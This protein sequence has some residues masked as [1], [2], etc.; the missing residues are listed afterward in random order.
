MLFSV[1]IGNQQKVANDW[2]VRKDEF[3]QS[4]IHNDSIR[5]R[6]RLGKNV[7]K[8]LTVDY[9]CANVAAF[10][11]EDEP[12]E[13]LDA[14]YADV[15]AYKIANKTFISNNNKNMNL[16]LINFYSKDKAVMEAHKEDHIMFVTMVNDNYELVDYFAYEGVDIIQTY[17][18]KGLYQGCVVSFKEAPEEGDLLRLYVKDKVK[19]RFVSIDISMTDKNRI[20]VHKEGIVKDYLK[21]IRRIYK[22]LES[23]KKQEQFKI[24]VPEGKLL[25]RVYITTYSHEAELADILKDKGIKNFVI[26]SIDQDKLTKDYLKVDEIRNTLNAEIRDERIRAVTT[27]NIDMPWSFCKDF[28]IMY[29]FSYDGKK[30]LLTCLK[31]N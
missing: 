28:N 20:L 12:E 23:K 16:A 10:K 31:S 14:T 29:L 5:Q 8:H 1:I 21:T 11:F 7:P 18:K 19:N 27:Y 17:R 25:T 6:I 15:R 4:Y 26:I 2:E 3:E 22:T 30:D 9:S 13:A 24:R